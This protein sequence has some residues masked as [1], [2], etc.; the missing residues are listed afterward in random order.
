MGNVGLRIRFV[1]RVLTT[2][3]LVLWAAQLAVSEARAGILQPGAIVVADMGGSTNI[4]S[5]PLEAVD[6]AIFIIDPLTGA[7]TLL[8]GRGVG[9]GPALVDPQAVAISGDGKLFVT[10]RTLGSPGNPAQNI[11]YHIDTTNG[12]RTVVHNSAVGDGLPF[13]L[14][15][16]DVL[17]DAG[18]Q[19]V[20]LGSTLVAGPPPITEY[21][22]GAVYRVDP[23]TGV[24]TLHSGM[25]TGVGSTMMTPSGIDRLPDGNWL[26]VDWEADQLLV[27]DSVSGDRTVVSGSTVGVGVAFNSLIDVA[28]LDSTRAVL[29]SFDGGELIGIDLMTG[30]RT[31]LSGIGVGTGP[32][33]NQPWGVATSDSNQIYL[34]DLLDW[35]LAADGAIYIVDPLTG[36][37]TILSGRGAGSGPELL[38]P[39]QIAVVAV[40]EP[41]CG[42]ALALGAIVIAAWQR[43]RRQQR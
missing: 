25:G 15:G 36:N 16:A 17:E 40:P 28:V 1:V 14:L 34:A 27:I 9:A 22:M 29:S 2:S 26:V 8:S 32:S 30:E 21:P 10:D 11:V 20:V 5:T 41:A 24:R 33:L 13:E 4:G 7:R 39:A 19:I 42:M 35:D 37:R 38:R 31:L 18:G 43:S 6:G 3:F 23:G 12:D